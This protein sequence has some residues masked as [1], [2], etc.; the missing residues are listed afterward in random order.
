MPGYFTPRK[1]HPLLHP[2]VLIAL[3]SLVALTSQSADQ[4]SASDWHEMWWLNKTSRALRGGSGLQPNENPVELLKL[5][6]RGVVERFMNDQRFADSILGFN[7]F[8]LGFRQDE[9]RTEKNLYQDIVYEL[10]GA[11]AASRAVLEEKSDYFDLFNLAQPIYL[12]PLPRPSKVEDADQQLESIELRHLNYQRIQKDLSD[13]TQLASVQPV[14]VEAVCSA[15]NAHALKYIFSGALGLPNT[16]AR[17]TIFSKN[18]YG[19]MNSVC[20][21]GK[22]AGFDFA[23]NLQHIFEQNELFF[24]KLRA[25]EPTNYSLASVLSIQVLDLSDMNLDMTNTALTFTIARALPNSSTNF[26]RKRSAYYLK[27]FFCDD[28]TPVNIEAPAS[29]AGDVHASNSSCLACHYKL[30]PLAG[31]FRDYGRDFKNFATSKIIEFDDGVRVDRAEYQKSWQPGPDATHPWNAGYIRS[32]RDTQLNSYGSDYADLI[33]LLKTAPEVRS[34]LVRRMF[35]YLV[36]DQQTVDNDYL[37]ELTTKFNA[38]MRTDGSV[39][40][41]KQAVTDIVLSKSFATFNPD[42]SVCYDFKNGA[43]TSSAT[44]VP[45]RVAAILRNACV[46]C[47][48]STTQEP[49]LD[50]SH[51]IKDATGMSG[52]PHLDEKGKAISSQQTFQ[53]MIERISSTDSDSRM[54]YLSEMP[55]TDRQ[56]LYKWLGQQQQSRPNS[57]L[58]QGP[59]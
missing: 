47:H 56:E 16:L 20:N 1:G 27:R 2:L 7:L 52:F 22:T 6:H 44:A 53:M 50:L 48:S 59:Q 31:F 41:L 45:C 10:P 25:F 51:F 43:P 5:G 26:N 24:K 18:W 42:R 33:S 4:G 29:H 19:T 34:C 39:P 37:G 36:S 40:A 35:E 9:V 28:L 17:R 58:H 21:G 49:Y 14:N 13:M 46:R 55:T 8:F 30:D 57:L 23:A 54:P 15:V 11:I 12:G 38:R 32:T 3:V